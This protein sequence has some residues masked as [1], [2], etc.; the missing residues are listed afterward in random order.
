MTGEKLRAAAGRL[1]VFHHRYENSFGRIEAREH[2]RVYVRG[3]LLCEQ[4]RTCEAIALRLATPREDRSP[5]RREVQA[6][7]HFLTESP[8]D[9]HPVQ[10]TTQAIFAEELA[11]S[12]A[13]SPV[14][15]VGVIDETGDEKSG[16]HS[17]GTGTQWFGRVGKTE[18]CQVG[19]F[20]LGV[21]PR[22]VALLDHQR[23]LP[24]DWAHDPTRRK[25]AHVPK[26]IR[27][28]T[29]PQ[30]AL[31]L[32]R[33]TVANGHVAFDWIA[34]DSL[35]GKSGE[36]LAGLE[37][38]GHR[39][40]A[41]TACHITFWTCDPATQ[42]PSK[43]SKYG[44]PPTRP[45]RDAVRSAAAIAADLPEEA[46]Q[47]IVL[48]EG[49]KGPLVAQFARL[50]VWSV[51]GTRP[52]PPVWLIFRRELDQAKVK[53][54]VS[55]A[56]EDVSLDTLALVIA[57]RWRVEEFFEDAK[58]YLGM[59]DCEARGWSSWHHHMSLVGVAH[60]YVTLVRQDLREQAP[61]LSLDAAYRLICDALG[62]P[63]LTPEDSLRIT[64][65]HLHYNHQAHQSHRKSWLHKQQR[66]AQELRL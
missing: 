30:I 61:E 66:L 64:K 3:L 36:F 33:R 63:R 50:R 41:E 56:A 39:Y 19:V 60:L 65:Y 34:A 48:R 51:R 32:I 10:A 23:F 6:M 43:R 35:Y 31:E 55:N 5:D 2:S 27:F 9:Y 12:A 15:V 1:E 58:E 57:T 20:L 26:E 62:R 52:G 44:K 25:K 14:G 38:L 59:A 7:Q 22:G 54:Y 13:A 45:L 11:P 42:V 16:T 28:R 37:E 29:K 21:A 47:P 46:W 8:W 49:A 24:K 17:C 18:V 53:Y 40:V 4:R